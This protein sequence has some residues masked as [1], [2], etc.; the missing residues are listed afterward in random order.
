MLRIFSRKTKYTWNY[1]DLSNSELADLLCLLVDFC[2]LL[3]SPKEL[4]YEEKGVKASL[5]KFMI[6]LPLY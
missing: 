4:L 2:I 5:L 1:R 6:I 3:F